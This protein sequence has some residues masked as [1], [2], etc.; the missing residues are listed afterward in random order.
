MFCFLFFLVVVFLL[1]MGTGW[2][3]SVMFF[4]SFVY[5]NCDILLCVFWWCGCCVVW[6]FVLFV[7][8]WFVG[9]VFFKN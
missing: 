7:L 6:L 8:L 4:P 9:C 3:L 5:Y 2:F 1:G